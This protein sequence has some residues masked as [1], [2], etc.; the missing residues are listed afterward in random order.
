MAKPVVK[1]APAPPETQRAPA[2]PATQLLNK[3]IAKSI[4]KIVDEPVRTTIKNVAEASR[5]IAEDEI[6]QK[7]RNCLTCGRPFESEWAGERICSRCKSSSTWRQ[8]WNG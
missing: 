7:T 6:D 1:K 2:K 5:P 3:T 8:G 4:H